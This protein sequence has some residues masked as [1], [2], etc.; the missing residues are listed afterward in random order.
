MKKQLFLFGM[1]GIVTMTVACAPRRDLVCSGSY[2]KLCE[3]SVYFAFDSSDV[4]ELDASNL[5]W[6][7]G[8]AR[9]YQDRTVLV[10]G[11]S[12]LI[13]TSSYNGNL[14]E[15][16]ASAVARELVKRGLCPKRITVRGMGMSAPIT[17]DEEQQH[18]N[19]RVDITF[20]HKPSA[21]QEF[22]NKYFN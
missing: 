1:L 17:T 9:R 2:V 3:P 8:K 16:R 22:F 14:S 4:G 10:T 21:I 19:R 13:G 20:G 6:V 12:D 18:L 7:A 11:H 15:R 5:N